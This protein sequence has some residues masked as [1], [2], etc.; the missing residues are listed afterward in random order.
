MK[1][2]KYV[3]IPN[4][5]CM[6]SDEDQAEDLVKGAELSLSPLVLGQLATKGVEMIMQTEPAQDEK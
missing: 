5:T 6:K 2:N 1:P 4:K 3:E